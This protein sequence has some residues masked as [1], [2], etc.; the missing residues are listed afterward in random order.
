MNNI[1]SLIIKKGQLKNVGQMA[2][3]L[4]EPPLSEI[5]DAPVPRTVSGTVC[6]SSWT[7]RNS[8]SDHWQRARCQGRALS[9]ATW[10]LGLQSVSL[11]PEVELRSRAKHT[12]QSGSM[13]EFQTRAESSS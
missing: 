8:V 12:V 9:R 5:M 1:N 6:V 7:R 3:H 2:A 11:H 4:M 13:W 10:I